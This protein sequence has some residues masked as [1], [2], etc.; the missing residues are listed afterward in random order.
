VLHLQFRKVKPECEGRLRAWFAEL[1]T[2]MD[3]VRQTLLDEGVQQE[4][5][6]ILKTADGPILIWVAELDDPDVASRTFA[7][8]SH[9]IDVEH[10]RVLSECLDGRIEIEP[11]LN[12]ALKG[13]LR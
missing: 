7:Q 12:V 10:D 13:I 1:S 3:E 11:S 2:R 8:S 5:A 9:P 6:Y 4:Q